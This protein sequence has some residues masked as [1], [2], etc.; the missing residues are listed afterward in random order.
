MATAVLIMNKK[1]AVMASDKDFS[2]FKIH[3]GIPFAIM[4]QPD[5]VLPWNRIIS[6]YR[7][8]ESSQKFYSEEHKFSE[9]IEHL[10]TYLKGVFKELETNDIYEDMLC[11]GYDVDDIFPSECR[12]NLSDDDVDDKGV[13]TIGL[14]H[15]KT[16][17]KYL[18]YFDKMD[19]VLNQ[20]S[21][22]IKSNIKAQFEK[23]GAAFINR[24]RKAARES[25]LEEEMES[26]I[27]QT[28]FKR[29]IND[30][31]KGNTDKNAKERD[32]ALELFNTKDLVAI[33]EQLVN[34]QDQFNHLQN[35]DE[36]LESTCE[37]ATMTRAEGFTWIKH[38]IYGA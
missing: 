31:F 11:M 29:A 24:L 23:A 25:G 20:S 12:I 14:K 15:D 37:I 16:W 28:N 30:Y 35:I 22:A 10:E 21:S 4:T 3:D 13:I 26:L 27:G 7:V 38:S 18:G 33:A 34:T 8:S 2:I 17:I 32:A 9:Y 19:I 36:P 5:S 1:A 6:E